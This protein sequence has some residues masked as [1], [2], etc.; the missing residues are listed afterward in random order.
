MLL[1][2]CKSPTCNIC[3][4]ICRGGHVALSM[5]SSGNTTPTPGTALQTSQS[6]TSPLSVTA[7]RSPLNLANANLTDRPL[8]RTLTSTGAEDIPPQTDER[9]A[10]VYPAS[11]ENTC[12]IPGCGGTFCRGCIREDSARYVHIFTK[13]SCR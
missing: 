6:K 5:T 12:Y 3:C 1:D 11:N 13:S 10:A 2:R 4:R 8:K 9:S 7:T